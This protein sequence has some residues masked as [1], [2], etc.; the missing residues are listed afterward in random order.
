MIKKY[1]MVLLALIAMVFS[2]CENP[3][4]NKK[5]SN[6]EMKSLVEMYTPFELT[7]DLSYLSDNEKEMVKVL[8]EASAIM[9]QIYWRQA[10]GPNEE[11]LEG[12]NENALKF[13]DINYGPWNRLDNNAPFIEGAGPKPT[14]ANFYP[15]DMTA[16][17]FEAWEDPNKDNLY[18]MIRREENGALKSIWYHE[19]FKEET[20]KVA[21]LLVKAAE[22]AEDEGLKKY[23]NLRAEAL[24]T[25]DYFASDM[26]WLDMKSSNVDL[27]IGPIENY[28]D[29][30][31]GYKAAHE[32]YILIKDNAWSEK[33][34]HF[35]Q[36]LPELQKQIPVDEKYKAETPGFD[37]DL[38]AYDVIFYA[39]DCNAGSK[40]IAINLPND[41]R[42]QLEKGTRRLQ[43]KNSMRAKFEKILV[44]ISDVLIAQDQRQF[45]TFDAFFANTMFHEVAHGLGIKNT[46][47]GKGPIRKALKEQYSALEEGKADI[48]G[49]YMVT[50]LNEM[51][52]FADTDLM[53]N[54]VTFMAGIFRSVRFGA[55][56]S[57][58]KANMVRFNYFL[59]KEAFNKLE[60]GTYA[61]DFEKMKAASE[62]LTAL[63]FEIQGEG[64]YE[65]AKALVETKG[66]INADLQSDLDKV[67]AAGIPTDIIFVQGMEHVGL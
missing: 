8:F 24:L 13:V 42:V 14:G 35:A 28:E 64:D 38:N 66:I 63:I 39:G 20:D 56:S 57:H 36:F 58:G 10:Y 25:D 44:P 12:L 65:A 37:T 43:L 53:E 55:A 47:N 54:Y 6:D 60:D 49:L 5:K 40:T 17:E 48:L 21:E 33:L 9:N 61:I 22:L 18:T 7:A 11:L 15:K 3:R 29:A 32:A 31:Y 50:N 62:D 30:L 1:F 52:E 23:L 16:D 41:E 46:I 2:A 34:A 4:T 19:Y 26:A 45:V 51:G 59:E 67:D 27:V